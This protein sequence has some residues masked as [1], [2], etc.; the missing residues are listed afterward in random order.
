[1]PPDRI[2]AWVCD[3]PF[4]ELRFCDALCQQLALKRQLPRLFRDTD[5]RAEVPEELKEGLQ[6]RQ[7]QQLAFRLELAIDAVRFPRWRHGI[8]YTGRI[9]EDLDATLIQIWWGHGCPWAHWKYGD[10][11]DVS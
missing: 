4:A 5:L 7:C 11:F 6:Q 1:M 8:V 2:H 10:S 3:I 9:E